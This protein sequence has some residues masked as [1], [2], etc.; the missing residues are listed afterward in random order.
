MTLKDGNLYIGTTAGE[1]LHYVQIPAESALDPPVFILATRLEPGAEDAASAK[2]LNGVQQLVILPQ[3]STACILC[4]GTAYF[5]SIPELS[6]TS[7]IKVKNCIWIGGLDQDALSLQDGGDD[8]AVIMVC[9]RT[10]IRLLRV[11]ISIIKLYRDIELGSCLAASRRG[12][13]ACA[14]NATS[15]SLLD[16]AEKA[17]IPLVDITSMPQ[18]QDVNDIDNAGRQLEEGPKPETDRSTLTA[19][20]P[21]VHM[22]FAGETQSQYVSKVETSKRDQAEPQS[23]NKS[24]T[25]SVASEERVQDSPMP[26]KNASP[27]RGRSR[28]H[29]SEAMTIPHSQITDSRSTSALGMKRTTPKPLMPHI[30]SPTSTE[31]LLTTGTTREEP[32]VGMFVNLDGDVVGR[33]TLEFHRYPESLVIDNDTTSED[34]SLPDTL[35]FVLAVMERHDSGLTYRAVEIQRWD[36]NSDDGHTQ[37]YWLHIPQITSARQDDLEK[38]T[39]G[40]QDTA[41]FGKIP[42]PEVAERFGSSWIRLRQPESASAHSGEVDVPISDRSET[43]LLQR[44]SVGRSKILL[45]SRD[46]IMWVVQN[47]LALQLDARLR[48]ARK[49]SPDMSETLSREAIKAIFNE[50]RGREPQSELEFFT[51]NY[52]RQKTSLALYLALTSRSLKGLGT[53]NQ[54]RNYTQEA[55]TSSELDPRIVLEVV[56]S[57]R[58][59]IVQSENGVWMMNGLQQ[60]LEEFHTQFAFDDVEKRAAPDSDMLHMIR[61]YLQAWQRKKGFGSIADGDNI[62]A[63]VDAALLHVLLILDQHSPRGR[64]KKGSTRAEL[65][66]VVDRG[67]VC[68]DRAVDLLE[69]YKR[70]YVLSRLYRK[71]PSQVLAT[72]KRLVEGEEDAGGEFPDGEQKVGEYLT[73]LKDRELV[74]EYGSWLAARNPKLGVRIFAHDDSKIKFEAKDVI[75]ILEERAPEAVKEYLEYLVFGKLVS[76]GACPIWLTS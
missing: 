48:R 18:N 67:L 29:G 37:K 63:T 58:E 28:E 14:A 10:K 65:Y 44:F 4:N 68:F 60:L 13:I 61:Q 19:G 51:F 30:L 76:C 16:I 35:G 46:K 27:V 11:G 8:T 62:F 74:Q 36:Q 12:N 41:S 57:L 66:N 71:S 1:V 75:R 21:T 15:Y 33:A 24:K 64:G 26:L 38:Q 53:H 54:D 70:L 55:L 7:Q 59:E 32:G 23:P 56:P 47:P 34:A 25:A 45:W 22:E 9:L 2:I 39:L 17:Q 6:P 40:I 69:Q 43:E 73:T 52:I 49:T 3:A 72:W 42:I 20:L 5:Y 31:F 50:L